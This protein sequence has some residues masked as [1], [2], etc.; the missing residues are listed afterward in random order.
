MVKDTRRVCTSCSRELPATSAYFR[1]ALA[2]QGELDVLDTGVA[3]AAD[4]Q[5]ILASMADLTSEE[6]ESEVHWETAG[7][8]C[9]ACRRRLVDW[10]GGGTVR[11]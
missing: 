4:P 9:G 1:F 6:A 10:L 7:V 3:D 11:H 5:A 2:I 8:L